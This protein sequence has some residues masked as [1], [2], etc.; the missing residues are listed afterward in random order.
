MGDSA[1]SCW[2]ILRSL[3]KCISELSTRG[4]G[5]FTHQP[6]SL[7]V[8]VAPQVLTPLCPDCASVSPSAASEK[9]FQALGGDPC[10]MLLEVCVEL[11]PAAAAGEGMAGAV[12]GFAEG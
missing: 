2:N 3:R 4:D 9:E 5:T 11:V 8:E 7:P 1:P 12:R 10:K 6:V